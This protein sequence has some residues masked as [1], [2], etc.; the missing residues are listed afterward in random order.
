MGDYVF[1]SSY[2]LRSLLE[3]EDYVKEN[4]HLPEMPS[5]AEFAKDGYNIAVMDNALLV[6]IEELTLYMIEQNKRIAE[7]EKQNKEL[8]EKVK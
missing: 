6:K 7:L 1:H 8:M 2:K 3:V 5:A 4:S